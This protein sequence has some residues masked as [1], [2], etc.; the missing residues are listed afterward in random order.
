MSTVQL[1]F[2]E[3]EHR[4]EI[5]LK[6]LKPSIQKKR[7]GSGWPQHCAPNVQHLAPLC[8]QL[9]ENAKAVH[10]Q[11]SHGR[12]FLHSFCAHIYIEWQGK[13]GYLWKGKKAKNLWHFSLHRST[14]LQAGATLQHT[15]CCID[16][17]S[18]SFVQVCLLTLHFVTNKLSPVHSIP[19]AV[20][21]MDIILGLDMEWEW[22]IM[23][24][25]ERELDR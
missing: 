11:Q 6:L 5:G 12:G 22:N 23:T 14:L 25:K 17:L 9:T 16:P 24:A 8:R 7:N 15:C 21:V 20:L 2:L 1:C 4:W 3:L 19:L 13:T 18:L 10:K